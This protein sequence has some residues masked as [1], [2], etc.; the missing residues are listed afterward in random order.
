MPNRF[1]SGISLIRPR[2]VRLLILQTMTPFHSVQQAF[3]RFFL[4]L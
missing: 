2:S 1:D 3:P 4:I